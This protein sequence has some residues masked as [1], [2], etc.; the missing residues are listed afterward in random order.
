VAFGSLDNGSM[1]SG[2]TSLCL[3][4]A[5]YG[6]CGFVSYGENGETGRDPAVFSNTGGYVSFLWLSNIPAARPAATSGPAPPVRGLGS[7]MEYVF[8]GVPKSMFDW[9]DPVRRCREGSTSGYRLSP[10]RDGWRRWRRRR[11][12]EFDESLSSRSLLMYPFLVD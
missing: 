9:L 10:W 4:G 1:S 6:T 7:G 5:L 2:L 3:P 8:L 12:S 11:L